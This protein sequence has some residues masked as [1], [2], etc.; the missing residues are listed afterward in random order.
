MTVKWIESD[1]AALKQHET[2]LKLTMIPK[3]LDICLFHEDRM[4]VSRAQRRFY[5]S[6]LEFD[7]GKSAWYRSENCR[8]AGK[9][10]MK[11]HEAFYLKGMNHTANAVVSYVVRYRQTLKYIYKYIQLNIKAA[12]AFIVK[13]CTCLTVFVIAYFPAKA[14]YN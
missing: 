10:Y 8:P 9:L 11:F 1:E 14:I 3:M 12:P 2:L 4:R 6:L 5:M 13:M 7:V